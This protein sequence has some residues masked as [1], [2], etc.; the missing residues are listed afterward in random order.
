MFR[1]FSSAVLIVSVVASAA[2]AGDPPPIVPTRPELKKLLEDSKHRKA[3]LPLP[4]LSPQ[5]TAEDEQARRKP[6]QW[7]GLTNAARL[8][9]LYLPV[10]IHSHFTPV[11]DPGFSLDR[12]FKSELFWIV[13]RSTNCIYCQGHNESGLKALGVAEETVAA[14][15]GPWSEF[16]PAQRAA[17]AFA[18]RLTLRP[19]AIKDDDIVALRRYYNDRQLTE[20]VLSVAVYNA[21]NRW[22]TGL[23]VPQESHRVFLTATPKA[24]QDPRSLVAPLD[25]TA[26]CVAPSQRGV[27]ESRAAV[28]SALT[29]AR[30]R[31]PRLPMASESAARALLPPDASAGPVPSWVRL[32]AHFPTAGKARIVLHMNAE[33]RGKLDPR[34]R[35]EIAW[36]AARNDRAWY[37]LDVVRK[38]L[39]SL[40]VSDDAIFALDHP[41]DQ[42]PEGRRAVFSLAKTLTVDPAL[43][44][45]RDIEAIRRHFS[46]HEVAEVVFQI[47][48]AAFFDRLTEA[49]AL[50]LDD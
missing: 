24:Y 2:E 20:L 45:E 28:E 26:T 50:P 40:G 33:S 19:D 30:S 18:R 42:A 31:T 10:E 3:W 43:V 21:M 49:A 34:L 9:R 6:N 11:D 16:E 36:I 8:R 44:E 14:L 39:V 48:E 25:A 35:A 37:A 5:E 7:L 27:L 17:F 13:S 41:G 15:D 29:A 4:P 47:T 22:T 38:R 32:L 23:D 46:D 1:T 12:A